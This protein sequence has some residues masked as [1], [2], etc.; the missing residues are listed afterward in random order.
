MVTTVVKEPSV[1]ESVSVGEVYI[2]KFRLYI[3]AV[4]IKQILSSRIHKHN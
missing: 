1:G 2:F 4:N 3:S